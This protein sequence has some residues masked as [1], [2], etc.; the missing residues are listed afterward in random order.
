VMDWWNDESRWV[1]EEG[2]RCY[3]GDSSRRG[4]SRLEC[5]RRMLSESVDVNPKGS[6]TRFLTGRLA[7]RW[8]DLV[9]I[10]KGGWRRYPAAIWP[11]TM[12]RSPR[13]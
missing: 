4:P 6:V 12:P 8:T 11:T 3:F 13:H 10:A 9:K 2:L 7:W 1:S 5:Y